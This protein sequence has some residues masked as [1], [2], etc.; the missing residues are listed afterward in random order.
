V[1]AVLAVGLAGIGGILDGDIS[2]PVAPAPLPEWAAFLLRALGFAGL[3]ATMA[4]M[5]LAAEAPAA[6]RI[7][8]L[9]H[10]DFTHYGKGG[11]ARYTVPSRRSGMTDGIVPA[12]HRPH[13]R[14]TQDL[15][16]NSHRGGRAV[17]AS[18]W[19]LYAGLACVGTTP[20]L[21]LGSLARAPPLP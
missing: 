8:G 10:G 12:M 5:G 16:R 1:L 2:S 15:A 6:F 18:Q 7:N 20:L 17:R 9:D 13:I 21:L 14:R 4:S 3:P 19:L 11:S